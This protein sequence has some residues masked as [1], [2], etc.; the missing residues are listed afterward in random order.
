M[1]SPVVVS[2]VRPIPSM[3]GCAT[4]ASPVVGPSP[5]TRLKTPGGSLASAMHCVRRSPASGVCSAGLKTI[6]LPAASP[7]PKYSDGIT[8]GKFHGVMIP[9]VP[10]ATLNVKRRLFGSRAGNNGCLQA[11]HIFCSYPKIFSSLFHFGQSLC[12][13]GL[14]LLQRNDGGNLLFAG[15]DRI[16]YA[17]ASGGPLERWREPPTIPGF[18]SRFDR[19]VHV[20]RRRMRD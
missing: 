6:V 9:Q 12:E 19:T 11:L 18:A 13:V 4:S 7:D 8:V 1:V 14:A 2:P 15:K 10:M 17:M 20:A 16:G 5:Q 3:P